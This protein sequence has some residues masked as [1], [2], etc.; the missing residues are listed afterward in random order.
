MPDFEIKPY[1]LDYHRDLLRI[2]EKAVLATHDFL[3]EEDFSEIKSF[4]EGFDFNSLNVYVLTVQSKMIGFIGVSDSKIEML[5]VDPAEHSKGY[6]TQ[7]LHF[8]IQKLLANEVSVNEQND[9]AVAFYKKAGFRVNKRFDKD[10]QGRA[11]PILIMKLIKKTY[12]G[13]N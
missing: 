6:G 1:H 3:K 9:K 2:W 12:F 13:K 11:Y 5:F 7:L 4:L 8:A 10:D